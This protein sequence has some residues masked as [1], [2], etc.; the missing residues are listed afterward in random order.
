MAFHLSRTLEGNHPIM[1]QPWTF[2]GTCLQI[3]SL[4]TSN[5]QFQRGLCGFR[6]LLQQGPGLPHGMW[7][8]MANLPS[9]K[10][11]L[12]DRSLFIVILEGR[13]F[14]AEIWQILEKNH[15][16]PPE[17]L[18]VFLHGRWAKAFLAPFPAFMTWILEMSAPSALPT[19]LSM[20]QDPNRDV[21]GEHSGQFH[22]QIY[23][24]PGAALCFS[25]VNVV[26]NPPG[27]PENKFDL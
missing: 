9:T 2:H 7:M 3:L 14:R 10:W 21:W 11:L 13:K 15:C 16:V 4:P 5:T 27:F 22:E 24:E 12:K 19:P 6:Y 25:D 8:S 26:T 20:G 1:V 17:C 23:L 18:C